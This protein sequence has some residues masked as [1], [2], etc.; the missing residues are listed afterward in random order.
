MKLGQPFKHGLN[1]IRKKRI[2]A[3]LSKTDFSAHTV[4]RQIDPKALTPDTI[5]QL[6]DLINTYIREKDKVLA[7]LETKQYRRYCTVNGPD[8]TPIELRNILL[9]E[10]NTAFQVSGAI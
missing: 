7:K 2:N 9:T 8:V 5:N 10:R 1:F 4:I 6:V 3:I